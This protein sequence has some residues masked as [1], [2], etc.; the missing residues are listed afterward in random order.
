MM[1]Y[2]LPGESGSQ[3]RPDWP[4]LGPQRYVTTPSCAPMRANKWLE[5]SSPNVQR[6]FAPSQPEF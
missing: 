5:R 6:H 2:G 3:I 1:G 4:S